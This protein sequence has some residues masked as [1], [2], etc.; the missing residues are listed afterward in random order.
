MRH[1]STLLLLGVAA[2]GASPSAG[3]TDTVT[4]RTDA[5]ADTYAAN[6]TKPGQASHYTFVLQQAQP[7]P[8]A[9][10]TNTW[11]VAI[12]DS[13]HAPV[14]GATLTIKP[15]MPDHGHGS[16]L[17]PS[18]TA[19]GDSYTITP[20]YFFMPGLW[21]TTITAQVDSVIDAAVFAFCIEG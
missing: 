12:L 21:Q 19:Q 16:S 1:V 2:C 5:R 8:P 20:L 9:K 6:L 3:N 17:V 13:A 7:A 11:T 4:C 15:F 14:T 18:A 10:D